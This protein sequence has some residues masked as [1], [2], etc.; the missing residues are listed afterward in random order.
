MIQTAAQPSL[1]K[2]L[3]LKNGPFVTLVIGR[4][5]TK[6]AV[7]KT[8]LEF[9]QLLSYA[10]RQ[11]ERF[12]PQADWNGYERRLQQKLD[13]SFWLDGYGQTVI[14]LVTADQILTYYSRDAMAN[15]VTV[16]E[17]PNLLPL[18]NHAQQFEYLL[19]ALGRDRMRLFCGDRDQL[20]EFHLN[21]EAPTTMQKALGDN[22][23]RGGEL[24]FTSKGDGGVVYHG[25]NDKK[26]EQAIDQKNYYQIVDQFV[27]SQ[28]SR[29]LQLPVVLMAV[30]ETQTLFRK[31]SKNP[32]LSEHVYLPLSP[33]QFSPAQYKDQLTQIVTQWYDQEIT[34]IAQQYHQAVQKQQVAAT[35]L[36]IFEA[37]R[38]GRIRKLFLQRP[39]ATEDD[40]DKVDL[41]SIVLTRLTLQN[42]GEVVTL[43][44]EEMPAPV[45]RIALLRY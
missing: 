45:P 27:T 11:F 17:H 33:A 10:H 38:A 12:V 14:M 34:V 36:A 18:V 3:N 9:K 44:K 15:E 40:L 13:P 6:Q 28:F 41:L 23:L 26:Q 32:L 24:N 42:Q 39:E 25:H 19:L 5:Q 8:Q 37:A 2:L 35:P 30:P 21:D 43:T 31:V 1:N 29:P 22:E 20:I 4:P 16:S 7:R